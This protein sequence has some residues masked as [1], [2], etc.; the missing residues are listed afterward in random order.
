VIVNLVQSAL[1][2]DDTSGA[3]RSGALGTQ[4][5][6]AVLTSVAL[7]AGA[8]PALIEQGRSHL[9][10][11]DLQDSQRAVLARADRPVMELPTL[12]DAIDQ[13]ALFELA[14]TLRADLLGKADAP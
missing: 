1:L 7:D 10:R 6:A 12:P 3:L 13:G 14:R 8:A 2:G 5:V 4:Q 9:E 11:Q